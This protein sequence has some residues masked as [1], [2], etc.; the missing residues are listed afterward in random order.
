ML[1]RP[2]STR[3]VRPINSVKRLNSINASVDCCCPTAARYINMLT[4]PPS[5]RSVWPINS[6]NTS[7]SRKSGSEVHSYFV[8]PTFDG[9]HSRSEKMCESRISLCFDPRFIHLPTSKF[10]FQIFLLVPRWITHDSKGKN[11][12]NMTYSEKMC[13]NIIYPCFDPHL[14]HLPT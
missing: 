11:H 5:T 13:E 6:I 8:R 3:S 10:Q 2:P 1:T 7:E 12:G 14:S 9:R 4:R